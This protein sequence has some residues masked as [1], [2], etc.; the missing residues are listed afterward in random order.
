MAEKE[1][2]RQRVSY[3]GSLCT[4]RWRGE[5]E[6]LKGQWLGVEWDDPSRGKH[7]GVYAGNRYFTCWS[8]EPTAAS[9]IRPDSKRIDDA[10]PLLSA[11]ID[12]YGSENMSEG[13]NE[14]PST[15]V[16][17]GKEV[18]EVGFDAISRKQAAWSALTIVSL[19]SLRIENLYENP[20]STQQDYEEELRALYSGLKWKELDLSRN[21][22]ADWDEITR[23]CR[24]LKDLKVLKLNSN[25]FRITPFGQGESIQPFEQLAELSLANCAV[26]WDNIRTLCIRRLFP[27]LQSV[28]LAFNPL[29]ELPGPFLDLQLPNL[30]ILDLTSC[31]LSSLQPLSPLTHLLSLSTL[32]LRSNP[33]TTLSTRPPLIFP[34]LKA[35]DLTSTDLPTLS[36]LIP[37][38]TTFPELS[39][40]KTSHAPLTTSHPS[41]RLI[42]I[43]RVPGLTMLNNTPI[44]PHERQNAE[45]YYLSTITPLFLAARTDEEETE[46]IKDHP[47]WKHLCKKYGEPESITQKRNARSATSRPKSDE[48]NKEARSY[49]P[50]SLGANL[51]TITFHYHPPF[52]ASDAPLPPPQPQQAQDPKI[53]QRREQHTRSIPN[54]T[55]I[56]RLKALVGRLYALPSLEIKLVLET[57]EWDPVPASKPQDD[58][59]SCSE[60]ETGSGSDDERSSRVG[61]QK[62]TQKKTKG[63]EEERGEKWIRREVELVDS[64]RPVGSWIQGPEASVRVES[65]DLSLLR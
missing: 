26:G 47:Q 49:P 5:I 62:K 38:P 11:L 56:Y 12:K 25:R 19:D 39:S 35:I 3:N 65:R 23:I 42:T 17:S 21:L 37:I 48:E 64:T 40:L 57:D 27:N 54:Q 1:L 13:A 29:N 31:N 18:D 30:T 55:D 60:D 41:P 24:C 46:I 15:I 10:R 50:H 9:F 45:L 28:C 8:K 2:V 51:I 16:I 52:S 44:A 36:S 33:L 61:F 43:A 20:L 14:R 6:G 32:N 4:V 7:D 53:Q 63:D 34:H 58:D 59:W 22:F